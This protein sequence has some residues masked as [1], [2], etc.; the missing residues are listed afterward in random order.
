MLEGGFSTR[1]ENFVADMNNQLAREGK[2]TTDPAYV[3]LKT[4]RRE[5]IRSNVATFERG[6]APTE[7]P[8]ATAT[9]TAAPAATAPKKRRTRNKPPAATPSA[10]P[11]RV[12]EEEELEALAVGGTVSDA[13]PYGCDAEGVALAPYGVKLNGVPKKRRGRVA[14]APTEE[15]TVEEPAAETPEADLSGAEE[16]DDAEE[17]EDEDEGEINDEDLDDLLAGL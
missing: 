2:L 9:A 8:V 6:T 14:V 17:E 12:I 15:P 10:A 5:L 13:A 11:V 7:A 4:I 16:E 1:L 3:M